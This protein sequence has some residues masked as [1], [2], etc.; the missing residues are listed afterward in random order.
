MFYESELD[1]FGDPSYPTFRIS[2]DPH[3]PI[4]DSLPVQSQPTLR[5]INPLDLFRDL[6]E[7]RQLECSYLF[8]N[9]KLFPGIQHFFEFGK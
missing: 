4:L 6:P 8:S 7:Q 2:S 9:R 1:F 5:A 3:C